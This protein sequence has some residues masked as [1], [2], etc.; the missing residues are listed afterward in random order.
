[1][2]HQILV[3]W[4]AAILSAGVTPVAFGVDA[5][6]DGMSDVWQ[7]RYGITSAQAN[8]D[9][10]GTGLTN[11][12]K[13]IAG[14]RP[15]KY[16]PFQASVQALGSNTY[17]IQWNGV[18]GKRYQVQSNIGFQGWTTAFIQE[19]AGFA[20]NSLVGTGSLLTGT[21]IV[22]AGSSSVVF[23]VVLVP[24]YDSDGDGLDDY[25]EFLLGT[26][27]YSAD[28]DSDGLTDIQEFQGF[29]VNGQLVI[30]NPTN[31]DSDGDG[32][33]DGAEVAS[34]KNPMDATDGFPLSPEQRPVR[35]R[36]QFRG[37]WP[38]YAGSNPPP[39]PAIL[40]SAGTGATLDQTVVNTATAVAGGFYFGN[41]GTTYPD[42][43]LTRGQEYAFTLSFAG[44]VGVWPTVVG[45]VWGSPLNVAADRANLI[46]FQTGK[47]YYFTNDG[48]GIWPEANWQTT[49]NGTI[50]NIP[51]QQLE[52]R[53]FNTGR[54]W[55]V[56]F[57]L[58]I[59]S[60]N[61]R[62]SELPLRSTA[63]EDAEE[64][65]AK[66]VPI[67]LD[68]DN[69]NGIPDAQETTV[70]GERSLIPVILE[71][72]PQ[73]LE[74]DKIK[75]KI[76]S[77]ATA[78]EVN[79]WRLD[80]PGDP[81]TADRKIVP[82]TTYD[83]AQLGLGATLP[84]GSK[85][86]QLK[87]FVE[88]L[89]L[90]NG[91][92]YLEAVFI[93]TNNTEREYFR[94]RVLFSVVPEVEIMAEPSQYGVIGDMVPSSKGREGE[95]HFVTPRQTGGSVMLQAMIV[96]GGTNFD[97]AYMWEGGTAVAG[98]PSARTVPRDAVGKTTLRI[99]RRSDNSVA[100][101]LNVWVVWATIAAAVDS[102]TPSFVQTG[103][104]VPSHTRFRFLATIQPSELFITT[105]DIPELRGRL[106][107]P[108]PVLPQAPELSG[109]ANLR[110]DISR[111]KRR[112]WIDS[113]AALTLD[114]VSGSDSFRDDVTLAGGL[115]RAGVFLINSYPTESGLDEI[116][117]ND[118][119][120]VTDED[121]NPYST[122][123][124]IRNTSPPV[125]PAIGQLGSQD[126]PTSPFMKQLAAPGSNGDTLQVRVHFVEFVRLQI[127]D[128][129]TAGYRNWYRVSDFFPW[130][131]HIL[132][133]KMSGVWEDNGSFQTLD[134]ADF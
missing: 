108:V 41:T 39:I 8:Q 24:S 112:K 91:N 18:T 15:Y 61:A 110:W 80:R 111:A 34:G 37:T 115:P 21:T 35:L 43:S 46:V 14:L 22:P 36:M 130:K 52:A 101:V 96:P 72:A 6:G 99:L 56:T 55:A 31:P 70:A 19:A 109:G 116:L 125:F 83:A 13:S 120:G 32:V 51:D 57:D 42:R 88:G 30:T 3:G 97:D 65:Q 5:D 20:D 123:E 53:N 114:D 64:T 132:Y 98:N 59:D 7:R 17:R 81:K 44:A 69:R 93:F 131:T 10:N 117:G 100:D 95:K 25:E 129:S 124:S 40:L 90:T 106:T 122:A 84:N 77:N 68:D 38:N 133:R 94:D 54:L 75:I 85:Q 23:R 4:L 74:W 47:G 2:R 28:T 67:N 87:F 50:G 121:N 79:L 62:G 118:D 48:G 1:M 29:M 66:R 63:E 127:G 58:D 102:T 104:V 33:A 73:S 16:D 113:T 9:F 92:R 86:T 126:K 60:L 103:F 11:I 89:A 82:G 78:A 71:V 12:Q 49:G 105:A 128:N 27:P 107:Q 76:D 134:N 26:N 119:T 45:R